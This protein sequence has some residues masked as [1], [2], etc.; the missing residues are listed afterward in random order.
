M[1]VKFSPEKRQF[2]LCKLDEIIKLWAR[3]VGQGAFYFT[4]NDGVPNLHTVLEAGLEDDPSQETPLQHQHVP[5]P[6]PCYQGHHGLHFQSS[7]RRVRG[8]AQMAKNRARAAAHQAKLR[9][10]YQCYIFATSTDT[11]SIPLVLINTTK[12]LG[13]PKNYWLL[14]EHQVSTSLRPV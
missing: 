8:P 5:V 2:L 3:G 6:Q 11:E 7:K 12:H 14:F 4:V 1:G 10:F 9:A 13:L